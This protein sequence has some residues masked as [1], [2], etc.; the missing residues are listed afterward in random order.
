[1]T[2]RVHVGREEFL[3]QLPI[4]RRLSVNQLGGSWQITGDWTSRSMTTQFNDFVSYDGCV[5]GFDMN[6]FACMDAETG[7]KQWKRGRYGNGQVL[8]L[9]S[10]GQLLVTSEEGEIVL[11]KATPDRL[12]ELAK[13]P[14]IEGKAWKPPC[15]SRRSFAC[16]KRPRGGLLSIAVEMSSD[17]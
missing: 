5:Y 17:C 9:S 15:T 6:I 1:M 10:E 16:K 14:A 13:F 7:E 2:P 3:I 12:T 4:T 11:L 8:L